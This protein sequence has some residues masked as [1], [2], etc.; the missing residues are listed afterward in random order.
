M[1][2]LTTLV[3]LFTTLTSNISTENQSLGTQ[4]ISDQ[5][6][7]LIQRFFDNERT[8]TFQTVAPQDLTLTGGPLA[9]ATSGT[10]S[11][12]WAYQTCQQLVV[13]SNSEQRMV[14]FTNGSSSIYWVV[15]LTTSATTAI[16]TMGIQSYI[17]PAT[18]SKIKN[19]TITIGQLVYTP[20][21]VQSIQEWTN[22]NALPYNSDIPA[23]FYIYQNQLSFWP[24]PSSTGNVITINYKTRVPDLSLADYTTGTVSYTQGA[25]TI[26]G[27]STSWNT[28]GLYPLSQ[29]MGV[30]NLM[31][32]F[33]PP[34]GDGIW[35]PILSFA[36][37]TSLKLY[38][39]PFVP[40]Y[41]AAA[42]ISGAN[43]TIGQIPLLQEDFHDMIVYGALMVYFSSVVKD[44]DKFKQYESLYNGKFALLEAYA[45]NKTVNVDLGAQPINNNPNLFIYASN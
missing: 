10:L 13:F 23:Y 25:P 29:D 45:A 44:L 28:T 16:S 22:L 37:D 33:T 4:L 12:A 19:T 20:A 18:V 38:I 21:P 1:K 43:Y 6:R 9:N 7:Y 17:L 3:N 5:H 26:T 24:L 11:S 34:K 2:S 30:F 35:Y 27:S 42:S 41:Q 36:S 31:I 8:Y 15:P 40:N 39:P 32:K 14:S